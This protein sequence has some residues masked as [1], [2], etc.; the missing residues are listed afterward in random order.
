MTP[1]IS[2]CIDS[3]NYGPFLAQAIESVLQQTFPD[4]ELIIADD[5][6]TD[7][8]PA[9]AQEFARTDRRI[10]VAVAPANLG[11]VRNRNACLRL[12]RGEYV[13]WL[14]ADDFLCSNDALGKMAAVLDQNHAISLVASAR[15]IVDEKG[16]ELDTWSSFQGGRPIAGTTVIRRCLFEQR[17]LIGGPSAVMFRRDLAARGCD[18][19]FCVMA[20]LEMWFHLLEQGCFAYIREPLCAI[21]AHARQQTER[22]KRSLAPALENH[23]LLEDFRT[24]KILLANSEAQ[25]FKR[26]S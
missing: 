5:C 22:D 16:R 17:N 9:I 2:V 14:H 10:T 11:M 15:K 23:E 8:S 7:E 25:P 20:D 26:A 4:F 24:L 18:E 1:K 21:R 19:S 12:A 6:S 13:K 3:Y